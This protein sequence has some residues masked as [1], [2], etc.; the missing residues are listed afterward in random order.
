MIGPCSRDH[1][2]F[3]VQSN[4][5]LTIEQVYTQP[6][7]ASPSKKNLKKKSSIKIKPPSP[8]PPIKE[9]TP[10]E[11]S[12]SSDDEQPIAPVISPAPVIPSSPPAASA[13]LSP[14]KFA[15]LAKNMYPMPNA[16]PSRPV[17][18]DEGR[19]SNVSQPSPAGIQINL[20]FNIDIDID[21]ARAIYCSSNILMSN[22]LL[23]IDIAQAI[24]CPKLK[25]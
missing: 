10:P 25:Y 20:I 13:P 24:Y 8:P 4:E 17:C 21:I 1:A 18:S 6:K 12:S 15:S 11:S 22:I 2:E 19:V 3:F 16:L 7:S 23:N 5:D 14:P 9:P